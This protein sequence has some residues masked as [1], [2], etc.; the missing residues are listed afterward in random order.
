MFRRLRRMISEDA[1]LRRRQRVGLSL[2]V[3]CFCLAGAAGVTLGFL[4]GGRG[5]ASIDALFAA[6]VGTAL[7]VGIIGV[8]IW[9]RACQQDMRRHPEGNVARNRLNVRG[10]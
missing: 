9:P 7:L 1:D 8:W 6:L 2:I 10:Q 4:R 5:G 3:V